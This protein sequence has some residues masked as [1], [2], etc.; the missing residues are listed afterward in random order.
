MPRP[1]PFIDEV[2]QYLRKKF[3]MRADFVSTSYDITFPYAMVKEALYLI[4]RVDPSVYS[5][6][7]YFWGTT[8]SRNNIADGLLKDSSTVKRRFD[9]FATYLLNILI[10]PDLIPIVKIIDVRSEMEEEA[11]NSGKLLPQFKS[12]GSVYSAADYFRS[13]GIEVPIDTDKSTG[14]ALGL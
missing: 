13:K 11:Y 4:K 2:K 10:H 1:N 14:A 6:S 9:T 12:D 3:M 5:D 8:R 7:W